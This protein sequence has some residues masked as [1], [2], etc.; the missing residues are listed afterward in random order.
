LGQFSPIH[1]P[2]LRHWC[3][4]LMKSIKK[5]IFR[6]PLCHE[7]C[8]LKELF[9]M[10]ASHNS[11]LLSFLNV[12]RHKWVTP[13]VYRLT[14][15][16]LLNPIQNILCFWKIPSKNV[17]IINLQLI[18]NLHILSQTSNYE[19]RIPLVVIFL[20]SRII[21]ILFSSYLIERRRRKNSTRHM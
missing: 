15:T 2:W 21:L 4:S 18:S 19:K 6:P 16:T 7:I 12:G 3:D 17:P 11:R 10:Q 9:C 1:P 5:R 14:I 8:M 13:Y 20:I